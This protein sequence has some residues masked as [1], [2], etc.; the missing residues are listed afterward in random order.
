MADSQHLKRCLY[1]AFQKMLN[2]SLG[3]IRL[4]DCIFTVDEETARR[5]GKTAEVEWYYR[6]MLPEFYHGNNFPSQIYGFKTD[7]VRASYSTNGYELVSKPLAVL[8]CRIPDTKIVYV[9]E[10]VL[11]PAE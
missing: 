11:P 6:G 3:G 8:V 7:C 10:I 2:E 5:L 9:C 1:S 4:E